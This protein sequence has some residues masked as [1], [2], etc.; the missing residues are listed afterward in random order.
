MYHGLKFQVKLLL[1]VLIASIPLLYAQPRG[2]INQYIENPN[3]FAE[4]QE[5]T[6]VPLVPF[7]SVKMALENDWSQSPYY[8][9]LDGSW[10]FDWSVNPSVAPQKFYKNDY[11]VSGWDDI[12]IPGDWQRQGYGWNIYRNIAEEF[13]P[14]DPPHVPDNINPV[15]SYRTQFTINESWSGKQIFLHFDGVKSASFVWVNG[16]YAGYDEGG[17]TPSEYNITKYIKQ[18]V[19]SLSVKVI[20]WSDGSYLEDQDMWRFSGI[21]RS[22]Y[23]FATSTVHIRDFFVRTDL[24]KNYKD[25]VLKTSLW[26]KNYERTAAGER[27]VRL[28]LYGKDGKVI[29]SAEESAKIAGDEEKQFDINVDINNPV[30]WSTEKP[31]LYKMTLELISSAEK[32]TE[33]L[34][35]RVGFREIQM[36][37]EQAK[38]NGVPIEFRGVN[39]HEHHPEF[40]R[41]MTE[42]MMRKDFEVMKQN[43][44]NAIRLCHYP[45]DPKFYELADEYGIYLVDEV[46]TETHFAQANES[47]L[48]GEN[49]FP[50]NPVWQPAFFE[51][52]ERMLQRDKN[53]PSVVIWSTGNETGTGPVMA[54]DAEYARKVDGTRLL[55]HQSNHPNGDAPF[56]DIYGPRYPSADK[57]LFFALNENRPVVPGE[58]M[59]AMGNS[60]GDFDEFWELTRKYP[61]LQGGFIW[62]WVD[63]GLTTKLI[64]TPDLSRNK[65]DGVLMGNPQ[66]VDGKFGKAIQLSGLDDYI[67][68][69]DHPNLDI[70]AD[71]ITVETWVFPRHS[72]SINPIIT[73]GMQQF[74]LEQMHPD[75]LQFFIQ[76][77]TNSVAAKTRV[78][79]DWDYNWH[80][81]AGIY[82]GKK[83]QL[84]IDGEVVTTKN[85]SG[86]IHRS[87][88]PVAIGKN[89]ERNHSSF[90]GYYSNS[91]IDN[92]R[93]YSRALKLNELGFSQ[94]EPVQGAELVLNFDRFDDTG[95]TF[96]SYGS[97]PFCINGVVF[98]D[99]SAQPETWQVKRSHAPVRVKPVDLK[100]GKVK[101][102]N[103][104]RFTNLSELNVDWKV[105]TADREFQKGQ[106]KLDIAPLSEQEITIPF[107]SPDLQPGDEAWLTISFTLRESTIWAPKGHE[108]AFDQFKL[109][110]DAPQKAKMGGNTT[111]ISMQETGDQIEIEGPD[112]KYIINKKSGTLSSIVYEGEELLKSG[113][114]LSVCRPMIP[115]ETSGWGHYTDLKKY[116][117]ADEWR[118][119]NLDKV[120]ERVQSI[121][122]KASGDSLVSVR[123][124]KLW[125][126]RHTR[127]DLT[128]FKTTYDY[129]FLA[130]G[131]ILLRHIV[132]PFGDE[133][134][135]LQKVGVRLKL[136]DK[137][138]NFKWYGRG[139]FDT[140][141][142]RK[143]GAKIGIYAGT[144]DQQY[145]PYVFP[146]EHGN[147]TDVRWAGLTNSDG[148]GL[149]I[150]A[151]PEMNVTVSNYDPDN[152]DRAR[153]PFQLQKAGY[154]TLD[155]DHKVTGVGGTPVPVRWEY[156]TWPEQYDY[157]IR[158][159]PFSEKKTSL[160]D[161][162]RRQ[163]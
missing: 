109:P 18:G 8:M 88:Y 5:P 162:Y 26:L 7:S 69:Y 41:T 135:H 28:K 54:K 130:S 36:I 20:R 119:Y 131:D 29:A 120:Q 160:I 44:V 155:I 38:I 84:I 106:L 37:D 151:Y 16:E 111:T 81:I 11:N 150:F 77:E 23:L 158:I 110:L 34:Y 114:K 163:N 124:D 142:D 67:E 56:V 152:I 149:A 64:R 83:V 157:T 105:Y 108:V 17:M 91:I 132:N 87:Y 118:Y 145:V 97:D 133:L 78:P 19:N 60:V 57:L 51:R 156:R 90:A 96:Y 71:Q 107:S 129:S 123:V 127:R 24:D 49:W 30:K 22:V 117:E 98:A 159:K 80:H 12:K 15:G 104:H 94:Q 161:L 4:N 128:G 153:Y 3:M 46:N 14:Y 73:K 50:E 102:L 85:F 9:S 125:Y 95:K 45:N 25:A 154:V 144:V 136:S 121:Q 140:Y 89:L 40:G 10:K 48:F 52:F 141:P 147:K 100:T 33:V 146:Q 35:E 65:I 138:Q 61:N 92:V 1:F 86:N 39:R 21:Y 42:D 32:V 70:T 62:D 75:S 72:F 31:N 103:Y 99:R 148:K 13:N 66:I 6:H 116:W 101:I 139:P 112:F 59:H 47:G 58:Y 126:T 137:L 63:Q 76:G 82:D 2:D 27:K 74:A 134:S 55:M 68:L 53:R 143:T 122:V 115:N 79:N 93:I 113:P 43:N